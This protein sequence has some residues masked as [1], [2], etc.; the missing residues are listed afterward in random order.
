MLATLRHRNFALLW[1]AGLISFVGDWALFIALPVYVYD[2]TGS[3]LATGTMFVAQSLPRLL[4]G[5]IAGVFVDRWDRRRTMI[6]ANLLCAA[7]LLLL[8]PV[9]SAA[10]LW[11]VYLAAFL[12]TTI[13]L[14]FQPAESAL[15]PRL[16]GEE[17]LLTANAL[18]ALSWELTRLVAPPLGGL[19]M[20]LYGI[21]SVVALDC[22]SFLVSAGT[23]ALIALP[24]GAAGPRAIQPSRGVWRT[25]ARDLAEGLRLV[26]GSRLIAAIFAITATAMVAEG[27]VNVLGFPWLKQVLH[28]GALER[29]WLASAQAIGGLAG[30]LLIGRVSRVVRPV[31]LIGASGVVLGLLSLASVNMATFPIVPS[32]ALPAVLSLRVLQ[33]VPIVGMFV[34]I[35]TLLQQQVADRYRGRVFG[36]YGAT[37]ALAIVV[38]QSLAGA[39]GD[40]A[41]V[42]PVLDAVGALYLAAGVFALL[43]L[44]GQSFAWPAP[45]AKPAGP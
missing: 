13:A 24:K 41:G 21:G 45:L 1:I 36:A 23:I 30:G 18:S 26:R 28:G 38:G 35:D 25:L 39:L 15:L 10:D 27:I 20:G 17:Q 5:S 11:L 43:L 4:L 40:R 7:A 42:V 2:L 14:F 31:H 8:L 37:S 34:S 16:V 32:L 44:R 29:G 6:A 12:Q 19:I 9:R 33:G 3:T 22:L